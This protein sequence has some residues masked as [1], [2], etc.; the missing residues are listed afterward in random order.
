MIDGGWRLEVGGI[1][2][3]GENGMYTNRVQNTNKKFVRQK[4][5]YKSSDPG[6]QKIFVH[7]TNTTQTG[8]AIFSSYSSNN[9]VES[10]GM[11]VKISSP[12][13]NIQKP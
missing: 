9:L 11:E 7:Y 2:T 13:A 6:I 1:M 8:I 4:T 10:E 5:T 3:M 12:K